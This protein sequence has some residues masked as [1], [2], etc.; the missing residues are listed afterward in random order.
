MLVLQCLHDTL[1]SNLNLSSMRP[2]ACLCVE[3]VVVCADPESVVIR[4]P[5]HWRSLMTGLWPVLTFV[6]LECST[7]QRGFCPAGTACWPLAACL[8][9]RGG[10]SRRYSRLS[11]SWSPVFSLFHSPPLL[12]ELPAPWN[13]F[14]LLA[15]IAFVSTSR[16]NSTL[17]L[18]VSLPE[19]CQLPKWRASPFHGTDPSLEQRRIFCIKV[20]CVFKCHNICLTHISRH[21]CYER[22]FFLLKKLFLF[23]WLLWGYEQQNADAGWSQQSLLSWSGI[24]WFICLANIGNLRAYKHE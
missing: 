4:G 9:W 6:C 10:W 3:F 23:V 19:Q 22:I 8:G 17:S 7:P 24:W 2:R 18:P 1:L 5:G 13:T 21:Y 14:W 16:V 20:F 12:P 15:T 11:A